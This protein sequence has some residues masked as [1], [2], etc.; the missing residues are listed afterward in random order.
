MVALLNEEGFCYDYERLSGERPNVPITVRDALKHVYLGR[1][2]ADGQWTDEVDEEIAKKAP[3]VPLTADDKLDFII[4]LLCGSEMGISLSMTP[5][6]ILSTTPSK[7]LVDAST[8]G[9]A[10]KPGMMLTAGST[11]VYNEKTYTVVQTHVSQAGWDPVTT[12]HNLFETVKEE[13]APWEQPQAHNPY[14]KGAK[15]TYNGDSW[16]SDIDN[17]VWAPGVYGWIKL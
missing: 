11:C 16:V 4:A 15:V 5:N 3:A 6:D 13:N 12:L 17:N 9:S 8:D 14:M 7:S 1:K 10:W 2:Y